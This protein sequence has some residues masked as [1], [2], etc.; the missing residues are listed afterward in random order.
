MGFQNAITELNQRKI[1]T[2]PEFIEK[3]NKAAE[4]FRSE[5]RAKIDTSDKGIIAKNKE[6]FD[7]AVRLFQRAELD[8]EELREIG[9]RFELKN[10]NWWEHTEELKDYSPTQLEEFTRRLRELR[11]LYGR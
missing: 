2:T 4:K 3:L 8:I 9:R 7:A 6:V 10:P 1:G 5:A 11:R